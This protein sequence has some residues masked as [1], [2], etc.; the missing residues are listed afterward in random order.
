M[1]T[2]F[3]F[4]SVYGLMDWRMAGFDGHGH[5]IHGSDRRGI[6]FWALSDLFFFFFFL[7]HPREI[8]PP[9]LSF[10]GF[11]LLSGS[12]Q[13]RSGHSGLCTFSETEFRRTDEQT[14]DDDDDGGIEEDGLGLGRDSSDSS[15]R[16][17]DLS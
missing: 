17:R 16:E 5:G 9:F 3:S 6:Y 7:F 15:G 10:P 11:P 2:F 1:M 12:V 13:V 4:F 8:P 14:D